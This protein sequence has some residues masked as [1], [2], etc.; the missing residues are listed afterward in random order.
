MVYSH[1]VK[2]VFELFF[3]VMRRA[4]YF[5]LALACLNYVYQYVLLE[6]FSKPHVAQLVILLYQTFIYPII[7]IITFALVKYALEGRS[8]LNEYRDLISLAKRAYGPILLYYVVL[9]LIR[10]TLGPAANI[11]LFLLLNIKF[12][13]VEP[14]I[15]FQHQNLWSAVKTS[16]AMTNNKTLLMTLCF[17]IVLLLLY[18]F[19]GKLFL[20][21]NALEVAKKPFEISVGIIQRVVELVVKVFVAVWLLLI[22]EKNYTK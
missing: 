10:A 17:G 6:L 8:V 5:I 12:L 14:I 3:K 22:A 18:I 21:T 9:G 16:F 7:L 19:F 2:H 4:W 20:A 13:F 15:C 11:V 1:T